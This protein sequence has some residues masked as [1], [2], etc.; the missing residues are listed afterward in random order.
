[1]D[2]EMAIHISLFICVRIYVRVRTRVSIS[3]NH[4]TPMRILG[5][6]HERRLARCRRDFQWF[7]SSITRLLLCRRRGRYRTGDFLCDGG[8]ERE[9]RGV[10]EVQGWCRCRH[11]HVCCLLVLFLYYNSYNCLRWDT[12]WAVES[13]A[14]WDELVIDSIMASRP[15]ARE[16]MDQRAFTT[17]T[18]HQ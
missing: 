5:R 8:G 9:G 10:R 12:D 11:W 4:L 18:E 13:A 7:I 14:R 1:M 2:I 16:T 3:N 6:M 17:K 15:L